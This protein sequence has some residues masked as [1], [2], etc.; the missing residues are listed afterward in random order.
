MTWLRSGRGGMFLLALVVGAASR[1]GAVV[2][3]YLVY[4]FTWLV[5]GQSQ[6]G[7]DGRVPSGHLPWLG[8][9]FYVLTRSSAACCTGR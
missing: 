7:Q 3:R 8:V 6:F 1:L 9:G 5:T 2:F 4:F